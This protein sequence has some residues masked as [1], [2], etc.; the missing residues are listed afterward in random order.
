[1]KSEL[2]EELSTGITQIHVE[3]D[4]EELSVSMSPVPQAILRSIIGSEMSSGGSMRE[5]CLAWKIQL[6]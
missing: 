5:N 6:S 3:L 4:R 1:M 2:E